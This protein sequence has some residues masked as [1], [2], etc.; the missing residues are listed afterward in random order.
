MKMSALL[1]LAGFAL[2][3]LLLRR[4]V[5]SVLASA[6]AFSRGAGT[7]HAFDAWQQSLQFGPPIYTP[8]PKAWR[9]LLDK[10]EREE[11]RQRPQEGLN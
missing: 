7:L 8:A 11:K 10:L 6:E 5:Q 2:C 9:R 4:H 1:F 3:A